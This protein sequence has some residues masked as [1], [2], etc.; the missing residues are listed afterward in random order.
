MQPY[1][2]LSAAR[3]KPN[4]TG[5]A[6]PTAGGDH[7]HTA[8]ESGDFYYPDPDVFIGV[9]DYISG[10]LGPYA[11]SMTYDTAEDLLREAITDA[12]VSDAQDAQDL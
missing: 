9:D 2:R 6:T 4:V 10:L 3:C 1:R 8:A 11:D 7:T 5:C 12:F